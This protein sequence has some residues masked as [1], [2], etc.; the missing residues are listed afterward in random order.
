MHNSS[1][2][3]CQVASKGALVTDVFAALREVLG[4]SQEPDEEETKDDEKIEK[5]VPVLPG[6]FY[7]GPR[8]TP[9]QVCEL[10][11][12]DPAIKWKT[13]AT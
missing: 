12:D 7:G 4:G 11:Q 8:K 9:A 6:S 3:S 10:V 5:A 13:L 1:V 2:A